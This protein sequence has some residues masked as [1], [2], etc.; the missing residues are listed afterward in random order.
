MRGTP[1]PAEL[2]LDEKALS[3]TVPGLGGGFL[4]EVALKLFQDH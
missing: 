3:L 2:P 4:E 1:R